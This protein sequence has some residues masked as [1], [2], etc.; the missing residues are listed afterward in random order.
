M[1]RL[2]V[3]EGIIPHACR[4]K[5]LPD[6]ATRERVLTGDEESVFLAAASPLLYAL[7]VIMLDCG[8]RPDEIHRLRWKTTSNRALSRFTPVRAVVHAAQFLRQNGSMLPW[9][10]CLALVIS[11]GYS[12]PARS[13][14]ISR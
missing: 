7:A 11:S 3:N 1:L 14:G 10:H 2:A 8:P 12:R 9:L 6:E 4:V 5:L 13:Q